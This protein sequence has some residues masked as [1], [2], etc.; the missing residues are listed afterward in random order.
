MNIYLIINIAY[1]VI[2]FCSF[3]IIQ[4]LKDEYIECAKDAAKIAQQFATVPAVLFCFKDKTGYTYAVVQF[5]D[6]KD[7]YITLYGCVN[8]YR[9]ASWDGKPGRSE[10]KIK[11]RLSLVREFLPFYL[12]GYNAD[13]T[14]DEYL[15]KVMLYKDREEKKLYMDFRNEE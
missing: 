8:Y 13:I 10:R 1:I 4:P 6:Y 12:K 3:F 11:H 15:R 5:D 9:L 2:T 14:F 7:D